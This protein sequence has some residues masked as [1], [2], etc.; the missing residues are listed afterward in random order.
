MGIAVG[1][2]VTAPW[3]LPDPAAVRTWLRSCLGLM[4]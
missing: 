4:A 2:R 3:W 1:S